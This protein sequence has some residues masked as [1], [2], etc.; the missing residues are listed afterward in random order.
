LKTEME[1]EYF[2]LGS[3]IT[4]YSVII[5]DKKIGVSVTRA[6]SYYGDENYT[7]EN[8]KFLLIKKLNGIFWSSS[9]VI[10]RDKWEKQILHVFCPSESIAKKVKVAYKQLKSYHKGNTII[11]ITIANNSKDLFFEK[12]YYFE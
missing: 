1:I 6:M 9:N 5:N 8:A 3:K 11:L 4:D 10:K 12:K 7:V 2:P